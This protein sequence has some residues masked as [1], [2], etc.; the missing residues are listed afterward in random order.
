MSEL[1][2]VARCVQ[3]YAS[4]NKRFFAAEAGASEHRVCG[5]VDVAFSESENVD[6]PMALT[7]LCISNA[8]MA[9]LLRYCITANCK[10]LTSG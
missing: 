1:V 3:R 4:S 2:P 6:V 10:K 5:G 7:V 8:V 9:S